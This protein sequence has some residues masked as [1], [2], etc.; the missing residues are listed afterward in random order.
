MKTQTHKIKTTTSSFLF[1]ILFCLVTGCGGGGNGSSTPTTTTSS[2]VST[3]NTNKSPV[4]T[5]GPTAASSSVSTSGTT[6]IS[7]SASDPDGDA[8]TYSWYASC[9]TI[10]GTSSSVTYTA[11]STTGTCTIFA[12]ASDGKGGAVSNYTSVTVHTASPPESDEIEPNNTIATATPAASGVW[13][14]GELCVFNCSDI[15]YFKIST[16][17]TAKTVQVTMENIETNYIQFGVK[18]Y[19]SSGK[20]TENY[21]DAP[22]AEKY[23]IYKFS[24]NPN[25]IYYVLIGNAAWRPTLPSRTHKY[26]VIF[27]EINS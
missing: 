16:S 14:N 20:Y 21:Y 11:S 4:I 9:G 8:L 3:T 7:V 25:Y 5:S 22:E 10:S 19:D 24:V 13:Y 12:T 6:T 23:T 2:S 26:S 17:S 27:T 18:V 1:C 15:D